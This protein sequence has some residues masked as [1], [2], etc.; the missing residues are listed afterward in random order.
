[1]T[2]FER[3]GAKADL[4]VVI[5]ILVGILGRT[6]VQEVQHRKLLDPSRAEGFQTMRG[7]VDPPESSRTMVYAA[8]AAA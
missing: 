5:D 1:M 6:A 4:A 8:T 7:G 3:H 2:Q